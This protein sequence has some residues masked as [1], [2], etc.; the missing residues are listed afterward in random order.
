M[1]SDVADSATTAQAREEDRS[2]SSSGNKSHESARTP[3]AEENRGRPG[4]GEKS[5]DDKD[6]Q[7]SSC[8]SGDRS[9]R[10]RHS[11]SPKRPRIQTRRVSSTHKS[12]PGDSGQRPKPGSADRHAGEKR[13]HSPETK[14][15]V[16]RKRPTSSGA[17]QLCPA[18]GCGAR[19][20]FLKDHVYNAHIPSLF[21]QLEQKDRW[22]RNIHRQR[23][24]GLEQLATLTLGADATVQDL[25]FAVNDDISQVIAGRTDIWGPLQSEMEALCKYAGWS[26]PKRFQVYPEL[27]SPAVLLYWRVLVFLLD[28]LDDRREFLRTYDFTG[29]WREPDPSETRSHLVERGVPEVP[30][31][32]VR[33]VCSDSERQISV[34]IGA[35]PD[36]ESLVPL[37]QNQGT[38]FPPAFDS[39][40]HLN[41]TARQLW[42]G[43]GDVTLEDI[44]QHPLTSC[45]KNTVEL[46]GG[47]MVFCDP[48]SG[49][50][51][52][53]MD[54][55]WKIAIGVHP[56]KAVRC[57]EHHLARIKALLD[58]NPLVKALGEIGLDR[59][60][61]EYTW[62]D[63][64]RLF[65]KLLALSRP[66]KVIVL[67]IRGSSAQ[68]S[69]DVLLAGLHYVKK[70][71]PPN[72]GIHLHCFTGNTT[73]VED[74]L[75]DFPNTYFGF[76]ARVTSFN[77]E[78]RE[79]LRAV[80]LNRLLK[81]TDSPYMPVNRDNRVN[82]P[83]YIGD[84]AEVV[85][86]V[87]GIE[88]R[89]L[90]AVTVTNGQQLYQ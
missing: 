20:K 64:D 52:P 11:R 58:T 60:E 75:D 36:P 53:L 29:R 66:D 41:R 38:A 27:N 15:E 13:H 8:Q 39:H 67:H 77:W 19:S 26:I 44:L 80:P 23:L 10:R 2:H 72:Q 1:R 30:S 49:F 50:T 7:Q 56:R 86:Q 74:W 25:M 12:V 40:F 62:F 3:A 31:S 18:G 14:T 63:Q 24:H 83:A 90:L 78:Q 45:P 79:G 42:E 48:E 81:E 68:H 55:K 46:V 51:I 21:H 37:L 34:T 70:A 17:W 76:T 85:A 88:M 4:S 35:R 5:R 59:T 22:Q 69:S 65:K 71:C 82:T 32:D 16:S 28:Q 43:R 84:V 57:P 89:E 61:P 87:R 6:S 73:I 33:V 9:P 47:V 54:G